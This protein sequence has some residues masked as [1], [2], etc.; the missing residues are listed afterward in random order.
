MAGST[1][2]G[3]RRSFSRAKVRPAAHILFTQGKT[4]PPGLARAGANRATARGKGVAFDGFGHNV[5]QRIYEQFQ[6]VVYKSLVREA[7]LTELF[8]EAASRAA[9]IESGGVGGQ[10]AFDFFA[11]VRVEEL[12]S[13]HQ[14]TTAVS[15]GMEN[16]SRETFLEMSH[17]VAAR[18]EF[19]VSV[20]GTVLSGFA[21]AAEGS[22][23][24]ADIDRLV[25]FTGA[26]LGR[27]S[28]IL[29]DVFAL[30]EGFLG[31]E[32]DWSGDINELLNTM[33]GLSFEGA[34]MSRGGE[35]EGSVQ[36][37]LEFKFEFSAEIEV[38][39]AAVQESDPIVLDLDGDGVE[40]TGYRDGARFDIEGSGRQ[41][42][43]AFVT[44]GD[45]FLVLHRNAN[46]VVDSGS[47]LFGD[48][49]GAANG[50]EELRKLDSNADG[51]IDVRDRDFELLRLFRDDGDGRTEAG[52]LISLSEA[53]VEQIDLGYRNTNE[54]AA[55]G[56]RI[57]QVASFLR[58][59]GTRG[60]AVD[61]VLSFTA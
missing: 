18:F 28:E 14:R 19:S 56:N 17:R 43:T 30:L 45:A 34:P 10:L 48:Q 39:E 36:I 3:S 29:N 54:S 23:D 59:D 44:G 31:G 5:G 13:F 38:R 51:L 47:E 35:F 27:A 52:E 32:G 49:N 25:E 41:V 21:G 46:G 6:A 2:N 33:S 11:Q 24:T 1:D 7:S 53:G 60:V 58:T 57:T 50:F 40:L 8:R 37:Q 16:G 61:A 9:A 26:M 4:G 12:V 22:K 55:G 42:G 20:S 15:E